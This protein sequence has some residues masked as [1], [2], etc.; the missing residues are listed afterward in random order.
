MNTNVSSIDSGW[1][2]DAIARHWIARIDAGPLGADEREE[3]N[4]WLALDPAH[5]ALLD[6]HALL[7]S[8]ASKAAFPKAVP[9]HK[10]SLPVAASTWRWALP[11]TALACVVAVAGLSAG[12]PAWLGEHAAEQRFSTAL[13]EHR[14]VP[15]ADGSNV[16]L[17]TASTVDVAYVP[18]AR[19]VRLDHGQGYFSVAKDRTRPFE[20]IVGDTIVRA[21][22]T[23]F[24]VRRLEN[25]QVEVVVFEGV[26][27]L[28]QAQGLQRILHPAKWFDNSSPVRLGVG[29]MATERGERLVVKSL[30]EPQLA[31]RLAWQQNR[32][33]F[34]NTPLGEAIEQV[35]RYSA[36]PLILTD[37]ALL[38]M[39]VTGSFST[40]DMQVFVRSLELGFGLK[41][42]Q[43]AR[44]YEI[45]RP[46]S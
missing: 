23:R 18:H 22:G 36:T 41:I 6:T 30:E 7:W 16:L 1:P 3:L 4:S 10:A 42:K 9:A 40:L 26:V 8:A 34:E 29:E 25:N 27:E 32:I 13:G 21:V 20:V 45:S 17:D 14:A 15:L 44:G 5:A 12:F 24:T 2:P 33:V 11:A 46:N 39:R 28:V 37:P 43:D 35:N 31:H 19:R 38:D